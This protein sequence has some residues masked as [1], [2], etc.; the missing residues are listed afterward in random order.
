L[1]DKPEAVDILV[2]PRILRTKKFVAA[3]ASA[4]LVVDSKYLDAA[5]K[6]GKL[7]SK[8]SLLHDR[9][10]EDRLGFRLSEAL[11]RARTNRHKLLSGWTIF[12]TKDIQGGFE[13][14]KEIIRVNGGEVMMYAGRTGLKMPP[15]RRSRREKGQGDGSGSEDG[16][17]GAAGEESQN[18]GGED[19][20]DCVYLVSGTT[21]AEKKLWKGFRS[22]A[23]KQELVPRIVRTDWLLNAAMSQR[24]RWDAKWALDE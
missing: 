16:E 8:P 19:E 14:Y 23:E 15:S 2:A 1:T 21:E 3:L 18:Q 7:P 17:G 5:L 12:V 10:T 9:E 20:L 13:T 24:V 4:P 6:Q 11:D 22:T